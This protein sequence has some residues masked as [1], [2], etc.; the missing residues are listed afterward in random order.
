MK[1]NENGP[2]RSGP[3]SLGAGGRRLPKIAVEEETVRLRVDVPEHLHSDLEAYARYFAAESGRRPRA[4][5][6]VIVGVL[7][8]YLESD[9]QFS[10]WKLQHPNHSVLASPF[11]T[12]PESKTSNGDTGGEHATERIHERHR[13]AGD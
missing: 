10:R 5:S 9:A 8:G 13:A 4:M 3:R 6:D 12:R 2:R 1:D 7:L 11:S